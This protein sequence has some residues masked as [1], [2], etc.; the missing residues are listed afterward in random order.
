[1]PAPTIP[2]HIAERG[3]DAPLRGHRVRSSG[4]DLRNAGGLQ[5][6]FCTAKG[7]AQ[8]SAPGSHH[9]DIIGMI[10]DRISSA[11]DMSCGDAVLAI[12]FTIRLRSIGHLRLREKAS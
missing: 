9:N 6:G 7:C 5:P 10:G 1:M 12:E 3:G 4:E 11:I 2:A 8:A